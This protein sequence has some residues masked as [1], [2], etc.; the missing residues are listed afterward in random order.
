[1]AK[2]SMDHD[3]LPILK[4]V[5]QS[6]EAKGWKVHTDTFPSTQVTFHA[7]KNVSLGEKVALKMQVAQASQGKQFYL[8]MFEILSN[9]IKVLDPEFVLAQYGKVLH[10][11]E[12]IPY[13]YWNLWSVD[14]GL[15]V[16]KLL[17]IYDEIAADLGY[18]KLFQGKQNN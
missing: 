8:T 6:L 15:S 13:E 17:K 5:R 1:M 18:P 12:Q 4:Y 10:P 16:S 2:T 7:K 9:R 14:N 11:L 3:Y